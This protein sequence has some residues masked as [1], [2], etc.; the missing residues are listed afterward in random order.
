MDCIWYKGANVLC[1]VIESTPW[2]AVKEYDRYGETKPD[3]SKDT[4]AKEKRQVATKR[5]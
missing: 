3:R 2:Y 4:K 1:I 5:G